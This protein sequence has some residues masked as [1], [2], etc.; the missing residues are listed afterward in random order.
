MTTALLL[1]DM[2]NDYFKD[3][4]M[5]LVAMDAAAQQAKKLLE[6][7]RSQKQPVIHI[8]HISMLPGATFF[9]PATRGSEIHDSV[10]PYGGEAIIVKK[11]PN[12]FRETILLE[13]LKAQGIE[14][15]VICGAMIHMCVDATTRAAKDFGFE[16]IVIDDAC[17]TRDLVYKGTVAPA[18]QVSIAFMSA[19][20][21]F[22]AQTV[23]A[24][25]Y[26]TSVK[27]A[28]PVLNMSNG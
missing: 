22:Y 19:L 15:L 24:D 16:C 28:E 18:A 12:S 14:Q 8:Q 6:H 13:T 26:I 20:S 25:D 23:S 7:F 5:E 17:A 1:I 9:L 10:A 4:K 3:G 27:V 11:F 21:Y 2:Q